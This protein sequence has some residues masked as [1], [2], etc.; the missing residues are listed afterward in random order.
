M[1]SEGILE[2]GDMIKQVDDTSIKEAQNLI[3]YINDKAVEDVITVHVV[4]DDKTL[5][6]EI[7]L[8]AFPE[9]PERKGIGIQLMNDTEV[10]VEPSVEFTS[11]GIGGPSAGLMFALEMYDQLIE[12]DLTKGNLIAGTGEIDFEGN[13]HRIGGADKKVVAAHKRGA[14]VF[15]APYEE[16]RKG[17]NYEEA[18]A[19]AEKIKTDMEIVPV[20]T[21]AEALD[22]LES[23][24]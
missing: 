1:P 22:Y 2:I 5:T 6:K 13:V 3:D 10:L 23:M 11:K 8:Q 14:K 9:D 20:D 7:K 18:K 16:G 17:S 15:F 21:F 19:A 4:R 24:E 12:E